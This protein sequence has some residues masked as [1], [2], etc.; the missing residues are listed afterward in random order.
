MTEDKEFQEEG[1]QTGKESGRKGER[2]KCVEIIIA[3]HSVI[4]RM[5]EWTDVWIAGRKEK[6]KGRRED[7]HQI[8][9]PYFTKPC[10][11]LYYKKWCGKFTGASKFGESLYQLQDQKK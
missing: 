3:G 9:S 6:R 5:S 2:N 1:K 11:N 7:C 8:V 4:R 10:T